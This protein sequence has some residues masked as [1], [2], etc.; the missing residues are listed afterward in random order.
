MTHP[1]PRV[2]PAVMARPPAPRPPAAPRFDRHAWEE[3]LLAAA[4]THHT[5]RLLGWAL[6]HLASASGQFRAG[7]SRDAGHMARATRL[8]SK[9]IHQGLKGLERAGLIVRAPRTGNGP[10]HVLARAFTLTLPPA[11]ER[12]DTT[13]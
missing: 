3:A 10:E 12:T 9:Q 4:L 13:S 1:A 5:D 8:T 2:T 11:A 7:T 6:A